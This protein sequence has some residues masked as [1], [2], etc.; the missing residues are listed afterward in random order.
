MEDVTDLVALNH[1]KITLVK[2]Y[3]PG[4][5]IHADIKKIKQLLWNLVNNSV[6]AV[7]GQG[8]IEI[9]IYRKNQDIY[10]RST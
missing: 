6:K 1:K 4:Y 9:N 5:L 8:T 10:L 2:K 3:H 7:S